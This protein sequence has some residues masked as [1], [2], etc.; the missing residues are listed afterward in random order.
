VLEFSCR[1]K[2]RSVLG[3]PKTEQG[4]DGILIVL[5]PNPD[6]KILN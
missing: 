2:H 1:R 3:K 4:W 6:D 5:Q